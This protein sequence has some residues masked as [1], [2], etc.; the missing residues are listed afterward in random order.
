L[1][2]KIVSILVRQTQLVVNQSKQCRLAGVVVRC[3]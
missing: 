2:L 1:I 3:N